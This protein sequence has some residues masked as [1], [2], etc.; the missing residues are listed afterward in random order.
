MEWI[1]REA[2]DQAAADG[3]P[4]TLWLLEEEMTRWLFDEGE[5]KRRQRRISSLAWRVARVLDAAAARIGFSGGGIKC[6]VGNEEGSGWAEL[7]RAAW[8]LGPVRWK[9]KENRKLF[10]NFDQDLGFKNQRIQNILKLDL[11]WSKQK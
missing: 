1:G 2:G 3:A 5:M 7:S 11:N 4:L 10:L 8:R 9:Q 6:E